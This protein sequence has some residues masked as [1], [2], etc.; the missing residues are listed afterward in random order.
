MHKVHP[1]TH[2]R[3][4]THFSGFQTP[5]GFFSHH[6][7]LHNPPTSRP[8]PMHTV[9]VP[10]LS[11]HLHPNEASLPVLLPGEPPA[12]PQTPGSTVKFPG[13]WEGGRACAVRAAEAA[14]ARVAHGGRAALRERMC[15]GDPGPG[16]GSWQLWTKVPQ[17]RDQRADSHLEKRNRSG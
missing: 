15:S 16:A 11:T 3:G 4:S 13:P 8:P 1:G 6:L 17:T 7:G 5:L 10:E 2:I 9:R 14:S 12:T